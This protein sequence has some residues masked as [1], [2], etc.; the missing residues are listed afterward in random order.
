M[1]NQLVPVIPRTCYGYK[2]INIFVYMKNNGERIAQIIYSFCKS[3]AD[4][5]R[6]VGENHKLSVIGL[7]VIMG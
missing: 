1:F 5:A 3:K 4:F 2:Y 6:K 7:L